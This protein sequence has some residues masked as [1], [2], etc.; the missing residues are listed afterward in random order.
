MSA[1]RGL[2]P[3]WSLWKSTHRLKVT[4]STWRV[5]SEDALRLVFPGTWTTSASTQTATITS[6]THLVCA[7]CT[8]LESDQK[9]AVNIKLLQSTLSARQSVLLN[10]LSEVRFNLRVAWNF[11]QN[12]LFRFIL[13]LSFFLLFLH[14]LKLHDGFMQLFPLLRYSGK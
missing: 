2:R 6:P 10:L 12:Y 8:F 5:L 1:S 9:T 3:S 7:P 4:N 11:F 13:K 14:R